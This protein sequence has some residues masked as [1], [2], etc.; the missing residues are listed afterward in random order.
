MID[1]VFEKINN[2]DDTI[3]HAV[4]DIPLRNNGKSVM[5]LWRGDMCCTN[6]ETEHEEMNE[7]QKSLQY[8]QKA[9]HLMRQLCDELISDL[10]KQGLKTPL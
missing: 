6:C 4:N 10:M 1:A 2:P 9:P 8:H 3:L 5:T 7:I